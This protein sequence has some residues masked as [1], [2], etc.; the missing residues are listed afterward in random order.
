[1]EDTAK[2]EKIIL[3]GQPTCPAVPPVIAVL[4]QAKA[5]YQY[6]NI[7]EDADARERVM[8]INNGYES[9]PTL[10]FP[11]GTTLTEPSTGELSDKLKSMGY[12][13]PLTAMIAGNF[14]MILMIIAIIFSLLR[15]FGYF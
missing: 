7:F 11:D 4:K 13:V 15:G 5:E 14:W 10:E 6:I 9:V 2:N 8:Q 12:T 1:M 3:Y